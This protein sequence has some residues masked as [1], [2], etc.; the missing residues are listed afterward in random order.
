MSAMQSEVYEAFRDMGAAEDKALKAAAVLGKRDDD[1]AAA[2]ASLKSDIA[3]VTADQVLTK[4][5][6]GFL[7]ALTWRSCSSF[8]RISPTE[9]ARSTHLFEEGC[10]K[11]GAAPTSPPE[12]T[13]FL[14]SCSRARTPR[15]RI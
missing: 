12:L 9:L 1:L 4:G 8:S 15:G 14:R 3:A 10:G 5:M 11:D 13:P 6:I 7:L 2:V